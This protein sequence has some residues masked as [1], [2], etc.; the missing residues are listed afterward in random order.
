MDDRQAL[1]VAIETGLGKDS[2][3]DAARDDLERQALP[4]KSV[5]TSNPE[6]LNLASLMNTGKSSRHAKL[7]CMRR[8]LG[9]VQMTLPIPKT[10]HTGSSGQSPSS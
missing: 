6:T 4:E 3:D 9:T 2:I 1:E 8:L 10:G 7:I 5:P